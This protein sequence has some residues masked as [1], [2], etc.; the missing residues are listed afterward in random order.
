MRSRSA[1]RVEH[2]DGVDRL[3]DVRSEPPVAIRQAGPRLLLVGSAAAPLGGDE[4]ELEVV[5]GPAASAEIGSAAAAMVWPGVSGAPS[6]S[7]VSIE[8][9]AGGALTWWP[10]P[11]VVVTGAR[12]TVRTRCRLEAGSRLMLVEE[13]VLGRTGEPA[14][15]VTVDLR[16]EVLGRPLLH[17]VEHFGPSTPGW[18]SVAAAGGA[19]HVLTALVVGRDAPTAVAEVSSSAAMTAVLP[20]SAS[21]EV[22]AAVGPAALIVALAPD[23]PTA[24][25]ATGVRHV[26]GAKHL[27]RV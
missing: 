27:Q 5:L 11:T 4:L 15:D 24:L 20:L 6:R 21:A 18:G 9:G 8:V 19:R 2:V 26:A 23:R 14:G 22:T 7:S 25:A 10:E 16:V 17:H 13:V 12:H 3:V 1:L